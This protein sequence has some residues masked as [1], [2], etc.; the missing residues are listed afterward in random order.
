MHSEKNAANLILKSDSAGTKQD[1]PV[2]SLK[3]SSVIN[4]QTKLYEAQR[5]FFLQSEFVNYKKKNAVRLLFLLH[6]K[7]CDAP[8]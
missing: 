7:S 8:R 6:L 1:V 3:K 5:N 2:I 4:L